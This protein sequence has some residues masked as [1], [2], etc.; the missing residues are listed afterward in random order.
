MF[1][2][3]YKEEK[4]RLLKLIEEQQQRTSTLRNLTLRQNERLADIKIAL[5]QLQSMCKI[6]NVPTTALMVHSI[7]DSSYIAY[8]VEEPEYEELDGKH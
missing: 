5:L 3:R 8:S 4:Q 2:Q 1:L 6:V 7:K